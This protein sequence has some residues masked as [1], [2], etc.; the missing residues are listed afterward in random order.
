MNIELNNH[1]EKVIQGIEAAIE[2]VQDH[3]V[4]GRVKSMVYSKLEEALLIA[5]GEKARVSLKRK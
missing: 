4:D 3:A 2:A 5:L 1:E